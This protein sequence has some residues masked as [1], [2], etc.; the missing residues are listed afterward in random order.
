MALN[1]WQ[2]IN[3]AIGGISDALDPHA[4]DK[5]WPKEFDDIDIDQIDYRSICQAFKF[6][7][8]ESLMAVLDESKYVDFI[9]YVV[10]DSRFVDINDIAESF[11]NYLSNRPT[12]LDIVE[13]VYFAVI[14][15]NF[16]KS[17]ELQIMVKNPQI[18]MPDAEVRAGLFGRKKVRIPHDELVAKFGNRPS[19]RGDGV[20]PPTTRAGLA[21]TDKEIAARG[22]NVST[23]VIELAAENPESLFPSDAKGNL[24]I[25]LTNI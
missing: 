8:F 21:R 22:V 9:R 1:G 5:F 4:S 20:C 6:E 3:K 2:F 24:S 12:P 10:S 11:L 7:D 25:D 16:H 15:A 13:Q 23:R 18:K 17:L 19:T 14:Q